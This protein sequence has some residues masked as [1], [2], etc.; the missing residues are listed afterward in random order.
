LFSARCFSRAQKTE[1]QKRRSAI[2]PGEN[3]FVRAFSTA[4]A[5]HRFSLARLDAP[6][7]LRTVK[8]VRVQSGV[9]RRSPK[10][11]NYPILT[12]LFFASATPF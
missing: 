7:D 3:G 6:H 11:A 12:P 1:Y 5:R 9:K 4:V 2:P 10:N 8:P